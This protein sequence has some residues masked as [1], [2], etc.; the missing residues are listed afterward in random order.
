MKKLI[1]LI[2]ALSLLLPVV[3]LADLPDVTAMSDQELKD[4]ITACSAEL[5]NRATEDPDGIL[6]F[7]CDGLKIYQIEDASITSSGSLYVKIAIYNELDHDLHIRPDKVMCNDWEIYSGLCTV[8]ANAK[9][10]SI[11]SF[12]LD[13]ANV[14]SLDQI[15]SFRFIWDIKTKD[16]YETVFKDDDRIEHRFW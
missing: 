16:T 6:I 14:S 1:I 3:A 8:S 11:M 7:E 15:E 4:M 10:K 13:D 9:T 12:S 2:L 5:R